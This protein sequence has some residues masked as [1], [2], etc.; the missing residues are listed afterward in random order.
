MRN[1][2]CRRF[3][4]L[5]LFFAPTVYLS[6]SVPALASEF[7]VIDGDTIADATITYRLFGIDAPETGQSCKNASGGSW[8]CGK[9]ATSKLEYLVLGREVTCDDRGQDAYDRTLAVCRAD[10][11][12]INAAM[13]EAG[14]AWSFR[15]YAHDYDAL[16]N[17]VRLQGV[18]VWQADTETPWDYRAKKW[19]VGSQD[20][21]EGCPIKGNINS[22]GERIYH[23]PW[24][25]WYS[26]TKVS[27]DKGERWFCNEREAIAAGWRAPR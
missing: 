8:K 20:A 23:A 22:K 27:V 4:L 3:A 6:L 16:E 1:I 24:S 15:K 14:L 7:R 13:I 19:D 9:A 18:G 2:T 11:V 21:P 12:N 17:Q 5:L 26:R 10:G 25:R